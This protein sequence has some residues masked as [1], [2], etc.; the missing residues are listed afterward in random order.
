MLVGSI[1]RPGCVEDTKVF[2]FR[3]L[4][5]IATTAEALDRGLVPVG[6]KPVIAQGYNYDVVISEE[7]VPEG[8]G[9]YVS[10]EPTSLVHNVLKIYLPVQFYG[11]P[12]DDSL[13]LGREDEGLEVH[14]ID[15]REP[16]FAH[17]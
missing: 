5:H 10:G 2:A 7:Q 16:M 17:E 4:E 3:A 15:L 6:D 8:A 13:D 1:E 11:R 14:S 9:A 12:A